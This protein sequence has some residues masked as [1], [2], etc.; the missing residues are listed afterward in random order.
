MPASNPNQL[1]EEF[2]KSG[3]FDRLR[4]ELFAEF[5]KGDHIS[6]F[7]KKTEDVVQ[8]RFASMKSRSFISARFNKNESNLRTELLQEIQRY[9]YVETTVNDMPI[10]SDKSF[11]DSLKESILRALKD[12]PNENE[13][14]RE[15]KEKVG[16]ENDL[17]SPRDSE[18]PN[19]KREDAMDESADNIREEKNTKAEEARILINGA[20]NTNPP[21]RSNSSCA[22]NHNPADTTS[23]SPQSH[24]S[25]NGIKEFDNTP[26]VKDL[27]VSPPSLT[28]RSSSNLSSLSSVSS[29]S[30]SVPAEIYTDKTTIVR[31]PAPTSLPEPVADDGRSHTAQDG[32][33]MSQMERSI[34]RT[35]QQTTEGNSD[36]VMSNAMAIQST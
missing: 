5:Q 35:A 29:R 18:H 36:V 14:N 24:L 23:P 33:P 1:V 20:I 12:Q 16:D 30:P 13:R 25:V 4:R 27:T 31:V 21:I 6:S 19:L 8:Q 32:S 3:E 26:D 2:K 11:D 22:G 17:A 9:P 10:F 15:L 7:N 28:R 34:A